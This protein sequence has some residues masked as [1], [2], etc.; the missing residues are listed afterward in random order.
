MFHIHWLLFHI[1]NELEGGPPKSYVHLQ[2][3]TLFGEMV[4]AEV[5]RILR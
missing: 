4:S 5:I 2:F 1:F 3:M